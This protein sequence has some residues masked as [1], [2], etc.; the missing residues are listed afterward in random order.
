MLKSRG[1]VTLAAQVQAR[2][3]I[4][5]GAL[6]SPLKKASLTGFQP[7]VKHIAAKAVSPSSEVMRTI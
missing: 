2:Q 1:R 6:T 4:V 3:G 5:R 7:T